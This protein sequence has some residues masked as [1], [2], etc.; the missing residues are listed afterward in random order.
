M[1]IANST[2]QAAS[3]GSEMGIKLLKKAQEQGANSLQ[4][5][6]SLPAA[7]PSPKGVG[8]NIDFSA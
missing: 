5:I 4:L 8:E 3:S 1:D 2:V 7:A 6:N